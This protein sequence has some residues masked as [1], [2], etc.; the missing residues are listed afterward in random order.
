MAAGFAQL[1]NN[2]CF[3]AGEEESAVSGAAERAI[4]ELFL[5]A[6][7]EEVGDGGRLDGGA[8][9]EHLG[10]IGHDL[11]RYGGASRHSGGAGEEEG[12]KEADFEKGGLAF[13]AVKGGPGL[14]A[15]GE[16]KLKGLGVSAGGEGTQ[17]HECL[18]AI[19]EVFQSGSRGAR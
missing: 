10:G 12:V 14:I 7:R 11:D 18:M 6:L 1:G 19:S 3:G 13:C 4:V 9:G 16:E 2:K 5:D 15:V 17:K 8:G